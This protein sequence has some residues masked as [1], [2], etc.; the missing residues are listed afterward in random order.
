MRRHRLRLTLL[1]FGPDGVAELRLD[2]W[3]RPGPTWASVGL[4]AVEFGCTLRRRSLAEGAGRFSATV[5][6]DDYQTDRADG[7]LPLSRNR[8]RF[9]QGARQ[10]QYSDFHRVRD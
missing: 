3:G 5:V 4:L 9:R 8:Q 10:P 1:G 2:P 7:R 6:N